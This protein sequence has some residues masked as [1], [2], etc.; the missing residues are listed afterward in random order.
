LSRSP[1]GPASSAGEHA[2][3]ECALSD[4]GGR[5]CRGFAYLPADGR[6]PPGKRGPCH[7]EGTNGCAATTADGGDR[8]QHQSGPNGI[9]HRRHR[10][11][12]RR[13]ADTHKRRSRGRRR[14]CK[15]GGETHSF[16]AYALQGFVDGLKEQIQT[17]RKEKIA[18][19]WQNYVHQQFHGKS[20][21]ADA[22]R[23][24]L[25]L[26]LGSDGKMVKMSDI[27][28]LS[29][30]LAKEYAGK[31][32]KTLSRDLNV[33]VEMGL[34]QRSPGRRIR[35]QSDRIKAFLPWRAI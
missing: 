24:E 32:E 14:C 3:A 34:I 30:R 16:T 23:R 6:S 26:Q 1:D 9:R 35:A 4:H 33:L 12:A 2:A 18:V 13:C 11:T 8:G 5:S 10:G 20:A 29:P 17:I 31:T 22:R 27:A 25:V 15:T 21:P 28:G 19:A 7:R